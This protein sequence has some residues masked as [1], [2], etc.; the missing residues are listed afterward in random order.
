[1]NSVKKLTIRKSGI[2]VIPFVAA[3]ILIVILLETHIA[4]LTND[5]DEEYGRIERSLERASKVLF[6]LDYTLNNY[7]KK[8]IK[9]LN[10]HQRKIYDGLCVLFPSDDLKQKESAYLQPNI[11]KESYA[12]IGKKDLC[13]FDSDLA[14]NVESR[15]VMA[16]MLTLLHNLDSPTVGVHFL[17]TDGYIIVSP[18]AFAKSITA[19]L[20]EKVQ[21]PDWD[22]YDNL[23]ST[24]IK[25][26]GPYKPK[27][28]NN[29]EPLL[30]LMLPVFEHAQDDDNRD[31]FKGT[32][33]LDIDVAKLLSPTEPLT[34]PIELV[35]AGEA[36]PSNAFMVE[37]VD[38]IGSIRM[39]HQFYYAVNYKDE[40]L[41]FLAKRKTLLT[42]ILILY[43]LAVLVL[44]FIN[45]YKEKD[46][47][48]ELAARDPLTG[49]RN[50]RGFEAFMQQKV[51][52]EFV[53]IALID[54]DNF[55]SINDTYGHDVGDDV[56]TFL[57]N[58]LKSNIRASDTVARF[59]GEE[60]IVYLT[61]KEQDGLS[62]TLERVRERIISDSGNVVEHGF[63]VSGGIAIYDSNKLP[64]FEDIFKVI[65]NKLY[66]AKR[67]GKNQLI[68]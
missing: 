12:V 41:H 63:T 17:H 48:K 25:V 31:F 66:Y 7:S 44:L 47:F 32:V 9:V 8:N 24:T 61:G 42:I 50:R 46:Y 36:V 56:I 23:N 2:F 51:H 43:L 35:R 15:I 26:R 30:T 3:I 52:S 6:A 33:G 5:I 19:E 14:S 53:A 59:G 16:P 1:M 11:I 39:H 49:L 45:S 62:S 55:K 18:Q 38:K 29:G 58:E 10:Q 37:A 4:M 40:V 21:N 20:I 60:F 67:H 68:H 65:D 28:L 27:R 54:I 64:P 34:S 13:N 57:A 22:L